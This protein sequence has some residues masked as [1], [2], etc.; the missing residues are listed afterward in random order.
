ML[1]SGETFLNES[2]RMR[3][4]LATLLAIGL[5]MARLRAI[6]IVLAARLALTVSVVSVAAVLAILLL[7]DPI[8]D[9]E[10]RGMPW[11]GMLAIIGSSALGMLAASRVA[12][13]GMTA[14]ERS[15]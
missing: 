4:Y 15:P 6:L 11:P 12:T 5:P 14:G 10:I 8:V 9:L 1:G 7:A 13:R 3:P 2:R